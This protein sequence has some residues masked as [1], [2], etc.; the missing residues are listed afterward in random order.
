[1]SDDKPGPPG[2]AFDPPKVQDATAL[3]TAATVAGGTAAIVAMVGIDM[4]TGGLLTALDAIPG[5]EDPP[6][7][8]TGPAHPMPVPG[9]T[10]DGRVPC[11]ACATPVPYETMSLNHEGYFCPRC[12][13]GRV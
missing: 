3:A 8:Y 6:P 10:A 13:A 4:L 7:R 9:R 1:M 12:A 2:P 11:T 5:G